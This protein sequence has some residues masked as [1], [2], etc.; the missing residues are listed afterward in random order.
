MNKEIETIKQYL[1]NKKEGLPGSIVFSKTF[2]S[3]SKEKR[4]AR[5][6]LS[7]HENTQEKNK[8]L[9]I[10]EK[11]EEI[12]YDLSTHA[13]IENLSFYPSEKEVLFFPL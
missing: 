1:N 4:V 2:L 6:F 5:N 9:F 3:F 8:V 10:L 7:F 13:D 12:N 11:N